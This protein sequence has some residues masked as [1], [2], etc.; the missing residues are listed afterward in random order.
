MPP[1]IIMSPILLTSLGIMSVV[2]GISALRGLRVLRRLMHSKP[3]HERR[4]ARRV[5]RALRRESRA[6]RSNARKVALRELMRNAIGRVF[7]QDGT[8]DDDDGDEDEKFSDKT[9]IVNQTTNT[10]EEEISGFRDAAIIVDDL[11]AAEEGRQERLQRERE[12][13]APE[14][15]ELPCPGYISEDDTPPAYTEEMNL[16]TDGFRYTPGCMV[17]RSSGA[18]SATDNGSDS[19]RL[20]YNK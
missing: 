10:M 7:G 8:D 4:A 18:S 9:E 3:Y 16:V 6:A 20:G 19:D 1:Q 15:Q 13:T 2:F 14:R 5:R 11:I 17:S 12:T